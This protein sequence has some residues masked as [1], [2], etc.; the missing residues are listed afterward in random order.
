MDSSVRWMDPE[1]FVDLFLAGRSKKT[2]PTYDM[3]FRKIWVHG[4]EIGKLLS[5]GQIW[6]LLDT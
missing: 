6:I 2:F 3:A 4:A 1:K 5:G